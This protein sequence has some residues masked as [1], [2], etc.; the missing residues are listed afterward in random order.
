MLF[1]IEID[2]G[3]ALEGY[4]VPDGFSEPTSIRVSDESGDLGVFPCDQLRPAV[5]AAGRH[6]SGVVGFRL[7][8]SMIPM[9]AS[10]HTLTIQDAKTGLL[11]YR[12][13]QR[14]P[15]IQKKI[16]RLET[17]ILPMV[18]LD[19]VCGQNFHYELHSI[20]RFG[21]ETALQAFHLHSTDSI[22]LSG[23]LL[24]RNYEHFL[25]KGFLGITMLSDPY[26]E[27]ALRLL[28]LKRMATT[29]ISFIGDRDK[30]ILGPAAE[31]LKD[32]NLDDVSSLKTLLKKAPQKVSDVLSS[33][34]TRLLATTSPEQGA[35]RRDIA[36]AI[37]LL[38]RFTIVG[39]NSDIQTFQKAVASLLEISA[40]DLV[41]PARQ[42]LL[43]MIAGKLR[44]LPIA[45]AML[46][47]DLILDHY[48]R[49]AI[50]YGDQ[51]T[52]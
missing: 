42:G 45:E 17:Q 21:H 36:P 46:E 13:P 1:G 31:Y 32:A 16:I 11:V 29:H 26:Y 18:R 9:L 4:L 34:L 51:R 43:D 48:V 3:E 33:P 19:R 7:D 28:L 47:E 15:V 25:D 50:S 30:L 5:S 14:A 24:F 23:R 35:S 10:R 27:M 39:H 49:Q 12:R 40:D 6:Q 37:D 2:T 8:E 22:Y 52:H 20:E 38:S 41:I 44:S